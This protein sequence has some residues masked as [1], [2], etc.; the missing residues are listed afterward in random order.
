MCN[1]YERLSSQWSLCSV[2]VPDLWLRCNRGDIMS[3]NYAN[4]MASCH[5]QPCTTDIRTLPHQQAQLSF[6]AV[7]WY[8]PEAEMHHSVPLGEQMAGWEGRGRFP[9]E[10]ED[11][12]LSPSP[13]S[14]TLHLHSAWWAFKSL[15]W[16]FGSVAP[17]EAAHLSPKWLCLNGCSI[18]SAQVKFWCVDHL[19]VIF[20]LFSLTKLGVSEEA[21]WKSDNLAF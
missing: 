15:K 16:V 5:T 1:C 4:K 13:E 8:L 9:Q 3:V 10:R 17:Q 11:R 21:R 7:W 6:P 18:I 19:G 12:S 2:C 20:S 14:E